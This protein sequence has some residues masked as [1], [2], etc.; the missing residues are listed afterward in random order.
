MIFFKFKRPS[1]YLA[2]TGSV[3]G[4]YGSGFERNIYGSETLIDFVTFIFTALD[5]CPYLQNC[6]SI[7]SNMYLLPVPRHSKIKKLN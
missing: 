6:R 3:T 7:D 1:K 5:P 4:I 2:R